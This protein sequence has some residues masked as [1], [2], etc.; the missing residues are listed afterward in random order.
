MS[1]Q[2]LSLIGIN[3][4]TVCGDPLFDN[5]I[6]ISRQPY[7]NKIIERFKLLLKM[8]FLSLVV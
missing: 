8:E 5:A 4:V 6:D 3:D 2:L 1:R 7:N